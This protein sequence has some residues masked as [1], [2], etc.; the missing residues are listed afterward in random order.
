VRSEPDIAPNQKEPEILWLLEIL[1]ADPPKVVLEVGTDRGG[2]LFLWSRVAAD[3]AV[4]ISVDIQ[5]MVGRL[6]SLSPFALVRNSFRRGTQRIALV[7]DVNS[8]SPETLARVRAMLS[9]RLVDFLFLD[10]DHRYEAVRRDFELYASLVRPGG[11]VAFHDVSQTATP[12]TVGTAAFWAEFQKGNETDE[13]IAE[14][15]AGYGIG[16]Y[17]KPR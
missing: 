14:G 1:A 8:Q 5:K 15:T 9:G 2:T 10:G 4:L 12:D 13:C 11:L 17:R 3:D 7:D 6:G 16:V